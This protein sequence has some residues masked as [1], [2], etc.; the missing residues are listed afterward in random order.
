MIINENE[1]EALINLLDDPDRVVHDQVMERLVELGNP[2]IAALENRWEKSLK[3]NQQE[4]YETAIKHIQFSTLKNE[5]L[6]WRVSGGDNLLYG[7]YLVSCIQYPELN[8]DT[9]NNLVNKIH[10]DIWL[11]MNDHLTALEKINVIN[12]LL[13]AIHGFDRSTRKNISPQLFL[14]NHLLDTRRGSPILMGLL[15]AELSHRLQLPVYGVNLPRNFLLCYY[16]EAFIE[17]PN[18][19]LFYINPFNR[20]SVLGRA[21]LEH[22]LKEA[23]IESKAAYFA[24]CSNI[25]ILERL[26]FNLKYAYDQAGKSEKAVQLEELLTILR[27]DAN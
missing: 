12:H 21:Q 10:R 18:R 23:G 11:E 17:D 4:K 8:Y 26:I 5:I 16:D 25:D 7:G 24:P 13:Y 1:L 14:I 22:F 20:G 27:G 19:I 9:L 15:Y 6:K 3:V 2:A